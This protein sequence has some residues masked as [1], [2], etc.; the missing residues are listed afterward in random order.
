MNC[1]TSEMI[2]PYDSDIERSLLAGSYRCFAAI[3]R[4]GEGK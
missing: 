3:A 4:P 1:G 2:L